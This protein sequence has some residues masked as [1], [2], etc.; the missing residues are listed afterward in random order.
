MYPAPAN[1]TAYDFI[2]VG[3]G[4]AG[5]VV[6]GRL[7]E[8]GHSVLLVEAG[9]PSHW[10]QG[11]PALAI[12]F[13]KSPYDW[14]FSYQWDEDVGGHSFNDGLMN[15]P[16][17]KVLGGS[18]MLNWMGYA[19]GH[20][21]DYDEW[22]DLGNPGWSYKDVL[23]YFKKSER[24]R[25]NTTVSQEYHGYD[26]KM[27]VEEQHEPYK[28]SDITL[29]AAEE[30]GYRTGD[31]N[32]ELENEGFYKPYQVSTSGGWR[33]GT[34]RS[35]VEP[36]LGKKS[37]DVLPF[38]LAH[39]VLISGDKAHGV[40]IERFGSIYHYEAKKE[41][42]LSAGAVSTPQILM[43]SGIG[44]RDELEKHDIKPV[45]NLP[46]GKNLQDH[47]ITNIIFAGEER[48][49]TASPFVLWNPL[50]YWKFLTSGKGPLSHTG[51]SNM[52]YVHTP[53]NAEDEV[54]PDMEFH[55]CPYDFGIDY[56]AGFL[57]TFN[58]NKTIFEAHYGH[59]LNM[60]G[61]VILPTL[62]RPKSR[63]SITLKNSDPSAEPVIDLNTFSDER[64]VKTLVEGSKILLKFNHTQAFRD[65]SI[66]IGAADRTHCKDFEPESDPYFDCLVRHFSGTVFHP[67]GTCKMGPENDAGAVVD[68]REAIRLYLPIICYFIIYNFVRKR[69]IH[70]SQ[71]C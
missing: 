17:G 18:S 49:Y 5:S 11:I 33:L 41:T 1:G 7:A 71:S 10:L 13:L 66:R 63:G 9:G 54:R 32:G 14:D 44:P 16:R 56:G 50:N 42:V 21:L 35:F 34:Y 39:K 25:A 30:L 26:G 40:Q 37:I 52:G 28:L 60:Y 36:L 61:F 29:E 59:R 51:I 27:G 24:M 53:A 22:Q 38:A 55:I 8:A 6:A 20:S 43:L 23:P 2:V 65:N 46:V 70:K 45:K 58:I 4:S 19:R 48:G 69:K 67:V 15:Y 12:Y 64:D 31:V 3:S 68:N 57:R 62:L 47:V